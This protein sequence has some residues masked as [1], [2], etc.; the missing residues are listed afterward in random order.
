M[1][2]LIN[3]HITTGD[4]DG[5]LITGHS[6]GAAMAQFCAIEVQNLNVVTTNDIK[7]HVYTFGSPRWG[8]EVM[9]DY[10]N[11]LITSDYNNRVVNKDDIVPGLPAESWGFYHTAPEI[12]YTDDD[13]LEYTVC[14]TGESSDCSCWEISTDDHLHYLNIEETCQET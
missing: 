12:H 5:I 14:D 2:S 11:G 13:P 3:S 9:A 7:V 4:L 1:V 8:N 10:Y 6:L